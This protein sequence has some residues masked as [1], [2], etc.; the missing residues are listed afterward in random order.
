M[1]GAENM[2]LDMSL[3]DHARKTG[4]YTFRVYSWAR[5]TLSLGRNQTA[6]DRYRTGVIDIVRRP[7]GGRALL[8]HRE[9]TYSVTGVA[10]PAGDSLR[11]V[12]NRVNNILLEGLRSLGVP[13]QLA[14][15]TRRAPGPTDAPCFETPTSGELVIGERKLAGSAQW[16]D[17]LA[18]L[19][20]GSIL[21]DDDQGMIAGLM[22]VPPPPFPAPATLREALGRAPSVQEVADK[23]FNAV[24]KLESPD[25]VHLNPMDR[26]ITLAEWLP[27]FTSD[28]WTWRR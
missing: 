10:G 14:S 27:H 13:V 4:E 6:R 2:A 17:D 15:S 26:G 21:I 20:H 3:M 25:A 5:P 23:L 9:V 19:Q 11:S 8:H 1:S 28:E 18:F 24:L 7:T 12:Y 22:T 16:R